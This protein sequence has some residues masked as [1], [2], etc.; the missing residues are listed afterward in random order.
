[1]MVSVRSDYG[2]DSEEG[3]REN[4]EGATSLMTEFTR[5]GGDQLGSIT[6]FVGA[7]YTQ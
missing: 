5:A 2:C 4:L 1:M 6:A 7:P 3:E